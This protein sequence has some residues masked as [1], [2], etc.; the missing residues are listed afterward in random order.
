MCGDTEVPLE[1]LEDYVSNILSV[2]NENADNTNIELQFKVC[3]C[4][5]RMCVNVT[6]HFMRA[7]R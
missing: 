4:M 2:A 5:W 7:G 6:L 1:Q 3:H